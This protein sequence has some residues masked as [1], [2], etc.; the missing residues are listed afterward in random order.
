M[1]LDQPVPVRGRAVDNEEDEVLV[2]VNL[3]P[4]IEVLRILDRERVELEDVTQDLE[5]GDVRPIEIK[6]EELVGRE[7]ML[8]RVPSTRGPATTCIGLLT[9]D[10]VRARTAQQ[11]DLRADG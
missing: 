11:S 9:A 6:P 7:Q 10:H 2:V 3:R 8:D 1:D 5:I 4:L